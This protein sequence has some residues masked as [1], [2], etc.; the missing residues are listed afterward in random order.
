[1]YETWR[2]LRQLRYTLVLPAKISDDCGVA[3][4]VHVGRTKVTMPWSKTLAEVWPPK[5][6][7]LMKLCQNGEHSCKQITSASSLRICK[8]AVSF[9]SNWARRGPAN[10]VSILAPML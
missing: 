8:S 9:C 4:K 1:M 10:I 7:W 3:A 5:T 2:H 6:F